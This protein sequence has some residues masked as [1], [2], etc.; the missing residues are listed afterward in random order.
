M[1]IYK[2]QQQPENE[3]KDDKNGRPKEQ[4]KEQK[5]VSFAQFVNDSNM[6]DD[7]K[8]YDGTDWHH[9]IDHGANEARTKYCQKRSED[10]P[11]CHGCPRICNT[12]TANKW[13]GVLVREHV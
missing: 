8:K 9:Q 6:N 5:N 12:A 2:E 11:S 3:K 4:K 1:P 7:E 13:H 10:L